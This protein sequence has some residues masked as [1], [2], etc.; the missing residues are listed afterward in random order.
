[1]DIHL[2]IFQSFEPTPNVNCGYIYSAQVRDLTSRTTSGK[3]KAWKSASQISDKLLPPISTMSEP[4]SKKQ[5]MSSL[6]Q[7][8]ELTTVVAD[9]G[10]FEGG[11]LSLD[12]NTWC[13]S[14]SK[15]PGNLLSLVT[16]FQL[17]LM[18]GDIELRV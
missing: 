18:S 12:V 6:D 17:A 4:Q 11:A 15:T 1:M 14:T 7:L 13:M 2:T 3:V 5:A 16:Y 10:D 8:R 9:T